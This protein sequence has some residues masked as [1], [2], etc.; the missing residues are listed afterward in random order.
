MMD[1]T[2]LD[3]TKHNRE[4]AKIGFLF[5]GEPKAVIM[6]LS[7]SMEDAENQAD[8]LIAD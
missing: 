4:Q 3:C 2:I 6:Q 1:D 7:I 8:L 5:R